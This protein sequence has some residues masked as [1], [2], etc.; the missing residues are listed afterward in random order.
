MALLRRKTLLIPIMILSLVVLGFNNCQAPLGSVKNLNSVSSTAKT[1]ADANSALILE[2]P[3]ISVD[4]SDLRSG[5]DASPIVEGQLWRAHVSQWR[6]HIGNGKGGAFT[7]EYNKSPNGD[8][9][10][11]EPVLSIAPPK[12]HTQNGN[13]AEMTIHQQVVHIVSTNTLHNPP[14]PEDFDFV[15]GANKSGTDLSPLDV[16]PQVV[17]LRDVINP[18]PG[19]LLGQIMFAGKSNTKVSYD[20]SGY[21]TVRWAEIN[22]RIGFEP[23]SNDANNPNGEMIFA[24]AAPPSLGA[25]S[26]PRMKVGKGLT[27]IRY[28]A[29][30]T[31]S[32]D[33]I[34]GD[35]GT[36]TVNAFGLF[37]QGAPVATRAEIESLRNENQILKNYICSRDPSAS[38]CRP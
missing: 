11:S 3:N 9:S 12:G 15:S 20:P 16:G 31:D 33:P 13:D 30:A 7:L 23:G 21:A 37:V 8:F 32:G 22:S 36:G 19:S 34:G 28:N 1:S 24:T 38:F 4:M 35:M 27:L 14:R 29:T 6:S 26:L 17:V 5:F 25:G 10:L 18:A 2:N